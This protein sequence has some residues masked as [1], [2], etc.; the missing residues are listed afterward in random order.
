MAR[1]QIKQ[2]PI[3]KICIYYDIEYNYLPNTKYN[4]HKNK[5]CSRTCKKMHNEMIED[6]KRG[7]D[8]H[9]Y[10]YNNNFT[11]ALTDTIKKEFK[12]NLVM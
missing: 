11:D 3:E 7:I 5:F 8:I 9:E 12:S 4:E 2:K 10:L 1:P 6:I